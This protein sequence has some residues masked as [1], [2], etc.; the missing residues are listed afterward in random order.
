VKFNT[1]I[2]FLLSAIFI[3][4]QS[5]AV[6]KY[7]P[8]GER[9]YTGAEV[10]I[11]SDSIIDNE[12][13]LKSVLEEAFRPKPNKSFL[14][15]KLGLHFYYKMQQDNPG[16]INK[17]LYKK[18]GEEPVYQSDVKPYEVEE[19][20]LN[21]LENRGFFYSSAI[22]EFDE[23]EKEA[24]ITYKLKVP[25]PY[26]MEK[27]K[28]DSLPEPV[29]TEIK[30]S[31]AESKLSEGMRFD[32][33]NMKMECERIDM[34]LKKIGYYNFNSGFLIF[35]ADTNQYDKKRFDLF[36][37]LKKDVPKKSIVPYKISKINVYANYDVQD[38][39]VKQ[40]VRFNEK[41]FI[42]SEDF[43]KPKY[44]DPY[45]T[46]KE[47]ELYSPSNSKNTARRLSTIGAYKFVNIQY[48]EQDST[49]TD[50]MGVL[51]ANIYLSP[52]NKR[53]L[54]AEVQAVSKSNNFAGPGIALTYSNRNLFKGGETYNTTLKFGYEFQ[55]G[56]AGN[57]GNRSIE[58]GLNNE[59]IFPRVIFPIKIDEDFF[60]YDIPKTKIGLSVDYLARTQ[61]YTL[62]SM[63][64]QF[65]YLW[66]ANRY[67]SHE[68]TPISIN[69]T[70]L[71]KTSVE[72]DSILD[73][74]PFLQRSFE[75]QFISGL[76]YSFTYNG[77]IDAYKKH[78]FFVNANLDV[79]GN[80]ISLLGK[81][82]E[83]GYK[84]FLGMEYAQYA[85]ADLDLRY[86]FNLGKGRVIATRLYGGYGMPFGNSEVMPYVKQYYS[87]GP[88]SVRAFRIR[89]LGPGTYNDE[90]NTN[91]SYFD[92][93]GNIRLEANIEYRF[94]IISFLKGAVFADA[95]N[96][97][98][99][100]ANEEYNFEDK[101]TSS[102]IN[103]LGM[104]VG[105]GLRV[106][107]Q[108]F[109][110]RFDFAA[111]F[112]DPSQKEGERFDFKYNETIFNFGI[113]YPF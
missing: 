77:M 16:F 86:H 103:E 13:Q 112:H 32:L 62:L 15:M 110:I 19:I 11:K 4:M 53:A 76:N 70:K 37:R 26:R 55:A 72:F 106:D 52:L 66:Q 71:M 18:I 23:K 75:Q 48:T 84:S 67:I 65:G 95:G 69:Y 68:I 35:E 2:I 56:G 36:L 33:A 88:Y 64:A 28:V 49:L 45:V 108:G 25:S 43:F 60:K 111:P 51:E 82:N 17:F 100:K 30:K 47:G 29:Y 10:E 34:D 78:Q 7:I 79:A 93:T 20:L 14:G 63:T 91:S 5:C 102:F 8:E 44:L 3:V 109:V 42:N 105:V 54:R 27:Y 104:G 57:S 39:T 41:N 107:V 24:S 87:G 73:K 12:K 90:D 83:D 9:L 58:L 98:N 46:M 59:L 99:S 85:K 31:V 97:W 38:S 21:R 89:S 1:K 94:P 92:R 81:E 113:G 101:F 22:S 74:N 40:K 96:I 6:K 50:S 80:S 61:L